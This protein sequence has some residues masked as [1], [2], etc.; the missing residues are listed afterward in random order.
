MIASDQALGHQFLQAHI[1]G[2]HAQ[3]PT[4][5]DRRIHLRDLVLAN[6]ITDRRRAQHDFMCRNA[7]TADFLDQRLRDDRQ[8][9]L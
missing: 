9:G 2:L 8:Q 3:A 7:P 4:R 6:Q 5:L 1:Q